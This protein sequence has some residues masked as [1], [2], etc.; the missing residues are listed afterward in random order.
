MKMEQQWN[1]RPLVISMITAGLTV[2]AP[3]LLALDD[4]MGAEGAPLFYPEGG[5]LFPVV[6]EAYIDFSGLASDTG[7]CL[8]GDETIYILGANFDDQVPGTDPLVEFGAQ[9]VLTICDANDTEILARC[10]NG[11]CDID[12]DYRLRIVP[13][14]SLPVS[15]E[16]D[17]TV[18]AVGND[19]DAS[20]ELNT[21]VSFDGTTLSVT[22]AGGPLTADIS[23]LSDTPTQVLDKL[24]TVD[25]SGSGLDA[26][27]LDGK[28][29]TDFA[30]N[31]HQHSGTDINT[32]VVAEPRIDPAIAR[33]SEISWN[34]LANI[35]AGFAD[36]VDNVG[37]T[38]EFDPQVGIISTNRIPKW[39]GS[40]LVS[41]TLFDNGYVGIGTTAP[42]HKLHVNGLAKFE[43]NGGSIAMSTPG[44]YPGVIAFSQDGTRSDIVIENDAIR[45]AKNATSNATSA[46]RGLTIYENGNV[47][48]GATN[49][50]A[51]LE[52]RG[53]MRTTSSDGAV[54]LWGKGRPGS[55]RYGKTGEESGLCTNGLV[56]FGLSRH[57]VEWADAAHACPAST[58]VCTRSERGYGVC[59]TTRSGGIVDALGCDG[60]YLDW[61]SNH[62]GWL[63]D[64]GV[65]VFDGGAELEVP[66]GY[67]QDRPVCNSYPVWCCSGPN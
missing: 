15:A 29:A 27:T 41:G 43:L 44:G 33:D 22:D 46:N 16:Y 23:S 7:P 56:L 4:L 6:Q 12:G 62:R 45:I 34:N 67:L 63:S 57:A 51:R 20:N 8:A 38:S 35:P 61:G 2:T 32:G 42:D 28:D 9:G 52:V 60:E 10:P 47:G 18:G 59:D 5:I 26:D 55:F 21:A 30:E 17:L 31:V 3:P 25:G 11:L 50:V 40:A 24:K 36:G 19:N 49:P 54:R 58:W 13:S 37:L 53:E 66:D 64:S 1:V 39:D 65:V 48:V 14:Q